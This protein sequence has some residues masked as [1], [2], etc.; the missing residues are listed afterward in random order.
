LVTSKPFQRWYWAFQQRAYPVGAIPDGARQR[1]L[2]QISQANTAPAPTAPLA[3]GDQWL[4]IGPAPIQ[5]GETIPPTP[6]SGRVT[7]M[8]VDP[9]NPAHWLIGAAQGGDWETRDSGTTWTTKTDAQA[10]LAMGAIAFAPSNPTTIY[11]GTG[12]ANHSGDSYGGA[13]LLKSTDGGATWQLLAIETFAKNAFSGLQV[14]PTDPNTVLAATTY[15]TA[16]LGG[17]NPPSPPPRGVF[18]STDGGVTWTPVL[19]GEATDL[20]V[21]PSNFNTQYAGVGSIFTAPST[22]GVYRS[23]DGGVT[24]VKLTGPWSP[25]ALAIGRIT[26]ALAPSNP[27]VL[28]VSIQQAFGS[29]LNNNNDGG[30][31]GLWVTTNATAATPTWIPITS[32]PQYC[33]TQCWYSQVL[34][35]DPANQNILYAGGTP[36]WK[37][38]GMTWTDIAS[39]R[40]VHVDQHALTWASSRLIVGNDG[41]IWSTT[42]GGTTYTNHNTTLAITQFFHGSVHRTNSQFALGG[43]Q[44]NGTE[45]W[46]GA[47]A[48]QE[49][50]GGD[51]GFNVMSSSRP[52]T[53]W[54]VSFQ[55]LGVQRTT[56]GGSSFTDATTGID[57]SSPRVFITPFVTCP[58][59]DNLF[60]AGTAKPWRS[61]N[62]FSAS[63][64]SWSVNGPDMGGNI[65]AL[66]FA[67][68]DTACQTY[69]IGTNNGGLQLTINGGSTWVNLDGANAVP[70]RYVTG[71]AFHPADANTLYVT[72]S[73]F[74]ELTPAQPGHVFKT[75]T[76]LAAA[77]TWTN[78]S[79]PMNLPHNA[80]A[81]GPAQPATVYVGTDLG[82]WKSTDVGS[83]WTHHGLDVGLP[84]VAVF[85]LQISPATGQPVAFT[86]GR[87]AFALQSIPATG[88][89]CDVQMS[90]PSYVNGQVVTAPVVRLANPGTSALAIEWKLWLG[91]PTI[92]PI[93]ILNIGA[94]GS[95]QLP[96]GF[97]QNF[98]PIPF[99]TVSSGLPRGT[100]ELSCRLFNPVTFDLLAEDLNPFTIQ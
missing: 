82:V 55:N 74:D 58:A 31:L 10:S 13:G 21:T 19:T 51:G 14:H 62:F 46:T 70:N 84:N 68:S 94:N 17:I 28:Y 89:V 2:E 90:L 38:N 35:V 30:L 40:G 47:P 85:D 22:N 49:I 27:N 96:A 3:V 91:V 7:A 69:A 33:G 99:F 72:L 20:K 1:A 79:P 86:H 80:I 8:A 61:T 48:W 100:Y 18:R 34:S 45:K 67:P 71:L 95:V 83:T 39:T 52:D 29:G 98:G 57:P 4:S 81:V 54:A 53:D 65:S 87:G 32:A 92:P 24:W 5:G 23:T 12:E 42:D 66:A 37:F 11:A 36:L 6:V 76:A 56:D 77:P 43:S 60:L 64:P 78:V 88:P 25:N 16:G 26:L 93:A 41:G 59:N 15:G 63:T 73:G 75:T 97:S 9:S 50:Y 44:D